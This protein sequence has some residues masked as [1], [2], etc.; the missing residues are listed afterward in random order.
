MPAIPPK[1]PDKTV[2]QKI[3]MYDLAGWSQADICKELDYTQS[4][5][6]TIQCCPM[7]AGLR[8]DRLLQLQNKVV[9]GVADR[10]LAGDP[11]KEKIRSLAIE[12][13]NTQEYLMKG[14]DS[15]FVRANIADKILDR[16][17]YNTSKEKTV[18]SVEVTEK[19]ASRFERVLRDRTQDDGNA[20]STTYRI[21][22]E[23]SE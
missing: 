15:E 17:G 14:A 7:Y 9:D 2:I 22:K 1:D 6:S 10:V 3:L 16:A 13:I 19:M 18:L 12:A 21:E 8:K 11:V 23:M 20:R 5:V 4:W